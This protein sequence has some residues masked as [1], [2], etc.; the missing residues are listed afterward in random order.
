MLQTVP[1]NCLDTQI[2]ALDGYAFQF[3]NSLNQL[4]ASDSDFSNIDLGEC[5]KLLKD[6]YGIPYEISL[7]F[8]KFEKIAKTEGERDIQYE[9]YN[10]INYDKLDLSLC[11]NTK[12]KIIIINIDL[13]VVIIALM[14]VYF[15]QKVLLFI[16]QNYIY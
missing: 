9:V 11:I 16:I 8:F 2:N 3:T 13:L 10:P 12:I 15:Q 4:V 14:R 6:T 5:E 7:V 1:H